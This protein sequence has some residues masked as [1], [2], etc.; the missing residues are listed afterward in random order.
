[1][2]TLATNHANS[3]QWDLYRYLHAYTTHARVYR[4]RLLRLLLLRRLLSSFFLLLRRLRLLFLGLDLRRLRPLGLDLRRL[5]SSFLLLRRLGDFLVLLRLLSSSLGLLLRLRLLSSS[6]SL[7]LRL[8]LLSSSF[9]SLSLLSSPDFFLRL[10]PP[11]PPPGAGVVGAHLGSV[12]GGAVPPHILWSLSPIGGHV[13]SPR[14]VPEPAP[15]AASGDSNAH[16]LHSQKPKGVYA[17]TEN[18]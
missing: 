1:M 4:F 16:F 17:L 15:H 5:L 18:L 3:N 14:A 9:S 12:D 10:P 13:M 7:L 6:F 11:A 2:L 8:R